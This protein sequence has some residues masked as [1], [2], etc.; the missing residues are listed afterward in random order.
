VFFLN[1]TKPCPILR[2]FS[3]SV[4]EYPM[5]YR[6]DN[7]CL[8]IVGAAFIEATIW[9]PSNVTHSFSLS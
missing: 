4:V 1:L 9:I 8:P 3:L 2:T 5:N 6:V 7:L